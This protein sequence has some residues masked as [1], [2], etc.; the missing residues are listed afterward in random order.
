MHHLQCHQK[1]QV[2]F[3]VRGEDLVLKGMRLSRNYGSKYDFI[4]RILIQSLH[5]TCLTYIQER[6]IKSDHFHLKLIG[7]TW[8]SGVCYRLLPSRDMAEIP[9]KRRKYSVQPTNQ[10]IVAPQLLREFTHLYCWYFLNCRSFK[11]K[12]SSPSHVISVTK[13]YESFNFSAVVLLSLFVAGLQNSRLI[14]V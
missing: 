2:A 14:R 4:K 11:F 10:P 8:I 5:R 12:M 13:L 1:T 3:S 6:N 7:A 9:L